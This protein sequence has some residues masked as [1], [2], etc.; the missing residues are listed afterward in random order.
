[1]KH[2][3]KAVVGIVKNGSKST[4]KTTAA[5]KPKD[6]PKQKKQEEKKKSDTLQL[7]VVNKKQTNSTSQN[8]NKPVTTKQQNTGAGNAVPPKAKPSNIEVEK[9][10]KLKNDK[11]T[12]GQAHHLN[13]DAAF[14]TVIPKKEGMSVKLEGNALKDVGTPHF[15]AHKTMEEFWSQYRKGGEKYRETPT[16]GEYTKALYKSLQDA[17]LSKEDAF[18]A[19][20]EAIKQRRQYGLTYDTP[21]PRIPGPMNS[22]KKFLFKNIP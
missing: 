17:G 5:S 8:G 7:P 3:G 18:Y 4:K 20:K 15:N 22:L 10:G 13:Q 9:Y 1:I 12:S 21:V 6:T 16:C 14:R 11:S 19:T 2:G